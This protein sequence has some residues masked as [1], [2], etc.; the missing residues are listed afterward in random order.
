[1]DGLE[2]AWRALEEAVAHRTHLSSFDFLGPW[3]RRYAG[4]YGGAPLIGT[5][6]RGTSLVGVAP[7]TVR[8]GTVG[9]VPVTRVEFAPSDVPAG[10]LLLDPACPDAA[11]TLLHS[12][13]ETARFD[14]VCLDGFDPESDALRALRNAAAQRRMAIETDDDA[15]ALVDLRAGYDA[16]YAR[17]SAHY[18]RNLG[19]KARKI[20]GAGFHVGGV[21]LADGIDTLEGSIGRLI[22][23]NEQSYKLAGRRL[24]DN[25]RQ[26]LADIVRRFGRRGLLTLPL[27][28]I[29]GRDAAFILGV[30]ERGVFY[31]ITLAYDE[32]FAKLSPGAFLMQR[33]LQALAATGVHSV[34]SHGAHEYKRH[35]ATAFVPQQRLFLFP[36]TVR[37]SAT[38]LLRFRLAPL[39]RRLGHAPDA[40]SGT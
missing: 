39:W 20:E 18:R 2:A 13:V 1:M 16:Y 26:F 10:E 28:A 5:A 25:H 4:E 38:R 35:W 33:M 15:Y 24:A 36:H 3:Y 40:A 27:L 8:R 22:A 21:R 37:A 23:I 14:V 9:R 12:L 29:G 11:A 17:L 19:Q 6:W 30:V 7:L 31:D 34:I 32:S